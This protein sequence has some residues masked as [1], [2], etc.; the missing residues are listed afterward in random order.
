MFRAPL[1]LTMD[2]GLGRH[3]SGLT[4][5]ASDLA[6]VSR[7]QGTEIGD[8]IHGPTLHNEKRRT[9]CQGANTYGA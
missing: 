7:S 4:G 3:G 8:G 5:R 9:Q 2:V 1:H 6:Y